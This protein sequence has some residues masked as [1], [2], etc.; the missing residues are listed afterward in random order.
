MTTW[1]EMAQASLRSAQMLR[2]QGDDQLCRSAISRAYYAAYAAVTAKL[3]RTSFPKGR[4]NPSHNQLPALSKGP[5]NIPPHKKAQIRHDMRVLRTW[6]EDADYR[7]S[8]PIGTTEARDAMRL[9]TSIIGAV[10]K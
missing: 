6:R 7:R 4:Q 1:E 5:N 2:N 9:A 8:K 3:P 10:W